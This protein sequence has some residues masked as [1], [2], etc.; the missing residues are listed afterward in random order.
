MIHCFLKICFQFTLRRYK[1]E[2]ENTYDGMKKANRFM[3]PTLYD[4]VVRQATGRGF[5]AS[6]S[7]LNLSRFCH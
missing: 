1:Q 5:H 6:T 4:T 3:G 7:Q 2:S